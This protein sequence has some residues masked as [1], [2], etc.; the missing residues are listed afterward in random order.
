MAYELE[1]RLDVR[2]RRVEQ[3]QPLRRRL[4][5]VELPANRGPRLLRLDELLQVVEREVEQVAQPGE[6]G[7]PL[8][9]AVAVG[10]ML[11]LLP[12]RGAGE[13]TDLLVVADRARRQARAFGNLT[14]T[15]HA[16][17]A[18][19]SSSGLT[20]A[21]CAG[22]MSDTAAPSSEM[23][24]STHSAA[25][26]LAMNGSSCFVE[27]PDVMP[28][29][30]LK[31]TVVGTADV[32]IAITNAIEMTAPVFCSMTRA[33]AA[34][35]RRCTGTTPIIAEVFGLL[36]MPEPMPTSSSHSALHTYAVCACSEVIPASPAAETSMPSAARPREPRRSATIPASGDETSIPI[37]IGASS[38]PATIGD[39]PCGPWK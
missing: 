21:A 5:L 38:S 12:L 31:S 6:L 18:S 22:R 36:N 28:E 15:D 14:D 33:P 1:L 30:I 24:V 11:A 3:A 10:A 32:T 4:R 25:C 26:I 17:S 39:F 29:K 34:M 27:S 7:Q 20:C 2:Q 19:Y 8:D 13:Q 16:A 23:P 35:P 37:A 9:V